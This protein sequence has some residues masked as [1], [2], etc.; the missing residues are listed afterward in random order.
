MLKFYISFYRLLYSQKES[1][2]PRDAI[3]SADYAVTRC[4]SVR[5]TVRLL[6]AGILSK[7]LNVSSNFLQYRVITGIVTHSSFSILLLYII[8][9]IMSFIAQNM[10]NTVSTL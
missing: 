8:I 6:H 1:I 2:L 10:K 3:H 5:L 9:I 7:R 4:P